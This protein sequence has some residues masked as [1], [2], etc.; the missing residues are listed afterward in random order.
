[1]PGVMSWE[2][3]NWLLPDFDETGLIYHGS[4]PENLVSIFQNGLI[5][6]YKRPRDRVETIYNAHYRHRPKSIPDWVD[7]R[8]CTF[9]YM[10]RARQGGFD[11]IVDGKVNG[12]TIGI[13]ATARVRNRTWTACF[14]FSDMVY[15][16][17]EGGYFDTQERK[18]F[19]KEKIEPISC[20]AYWKTSLSFDENLK[21]RWDHLFTMQE[22]HE[23]LICTEIA[24][25]LL[26]LQGF[27]VRGTNG[28]REVLRSDLREV[29]LNAEEKLQNNAEIAQ[30]LKEVAE[31]CGSSVPE[32][33]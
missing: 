18:T 11:S 26:S 21:I 29:F 6:G 24:P 13:E 14:L 1:M 27:R 5:P 23:L 30:E 17:E 7:P 20:E 32:M 33:D 3:M 10:N 8:Q 28:I 25:E 19:F 31:F 15:C 4:R 16:P 9:G 12:V 22:Y 2:E